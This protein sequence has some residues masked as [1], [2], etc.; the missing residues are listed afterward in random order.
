MG[1]VYNAVAERLIEESR[2]RSRHFLSVISEEILNNQAS[3][4]IGSGVSRNSGLPS[5]SQL[6]QPVAEHLNLEIAQDSDLF[7][8]AQYY[9]NKNSDAELRKLVGRSINATPSTNEIL[10]LI[11]DIGVNSI[12]TTNYD[13][14]IE[15]GLESRLI[16]YNAISNDRNL[17]SI[18]K[19]DAINIYK[20]N[21]DISDPLNMVLTKHDYEQ[22]RVR[23]PLFLTYLRRELVANTFLFVGYSFK[24]DIV[25]SCLS[26]IN[27]YLGTGSNC[28]YAIMPVGDDTTQDFAYFITDLKK[29]YNIECLCMRLEEIPSFLQTLN[30]I[31]RENKV[32]ISGAYDDVPPEVDTFADELSSALVNELLRNKFR[33]STGV[34]RHLGTLITGYAHQYLAENNIPNPTK[35]L[36]MRPFPFHLKLDNDKKIKYRTIMQRDC[37]AAIFMFGQSRFAPG[38]GHHSLGVYQEYTIAKELGLA[39]IP[40]GATGYEAEI[41]WKEVKSEINRYYYLGEGRID[42]LQTCKDPN[43]LAMLIVEILRDITKYRRIQ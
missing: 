36:S 19:Y 18:D 14:N 29:R 20:M 31:I 34:G 43:T 23:H 24:D 8:I 40:V 10:E 41:I 9:V 2:E 6:L 30:F 4:F 17:A 38:T 7:A 3:L 21:G 32:F 26:A 13:K 27:E 16:R 11:L 12:W 15:H 42:V 5:W 33:I 35:Q 28:H 1:E 39:I 22:Y 25:L 37:S